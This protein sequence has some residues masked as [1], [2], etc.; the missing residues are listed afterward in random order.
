VRTD[1]AVL[2]EI[3]REYDLVE[4]AAAAGQTA[5]GPA[6]G[7]TA[8]PLGAPESGRALSSEPNARARGDG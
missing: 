2:R 1:W 7:E 6:S 4:A 5:G 8:S 3:R